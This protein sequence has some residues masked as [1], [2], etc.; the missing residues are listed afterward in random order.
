[1]V[2]T[3]TINLNKS[4]KFDLSK[5]G[6]NNGI[7]LNKPSN[8]NLNK[9]GL[10]NNP[11]KNSPFNLFNFN[12]P[13][14]PEIVEAFDGLVPIGD[15]G[16]YITP[17]SPVD[18]TD[19]DLYPDSPYCGGNPISFSTLLGIEPAIVWDECNIGVQFTPVVGFIKL[20][21]LQFVYKDPKCINP[22]KPPEVFE[23]SYEFCLPVSNWGYYH[24]C[25]TITYSGQ[26]SPN[27]QDDVR[28]HWT[29]DDYVVVEHENYTGG[30]WKK[31]DM[32]F[33][34]KFDPNILFDRICFFKDGIDS[35][36]SIK[37]RFVAFG[38][39][40]SFSV[41]LPLRWDP[42]TFK[43]ESIIPCDLKT[44]PPPL[45]NNCCCPAN[46]DLLKAILSYVET[47]TQN[48]G[49]Y[50]H[51]AVIYDQDETEPDAQKKI[52]QLN[53]VADALNLLTSRVETA[54]K[55]IGI[56]EYPASLP[57][58]LISKDEGFVGNLI[59]NP[60]V[61]IP[62]LTRL[63]GWFVER[64]DELVGQFEI[65]IEIKDTD[66]TTP[67]DQPVGLKI[68]NVA[69]GL[70]EML[71]LLLQTAYNTEALININTR[72]LVETGGDKVQNYKT[73]ML[74]EALTEYIGFKYNEVIKK[75]NLT[76]KPGA[77]GLDQMLKEHQQDVLVAD[78]D[79]KL[80]FQSD[81][82]RLLEA[83]SIVKAVHFR[84]LD[85]KGD[86][87]GQILDLLKKSLDVGKKVNG[88]EENAEGDNS[89]DQFRQEVEEG[90]INTPGVKNTTNPYGRPF[91]D[92][93]RIKDVD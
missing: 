33:T 37:W 4:L 93:P 2:K 91:E 89:F 30:Y 87:K 35:I 72:T 86:V 25:A 36:P 1:M 7:D 69:E 28:R 11:K 68:T 27:T 51:N 53:S 76:F 61:E 39:S 66:P 92:R 16:W 49:Y 82:Q 13:G 85:V 26:A 77:E 52:I 58:S 31:K 46:D 73:Y 47:I 5:P 23:N 90:F 60:N 41:P 80:D 81:L 65:P 21:P 55:I 84:R 88:N 79:E 50:P 63:V 10:S 34:W 6:Q 22:L 38:K 57:Q 12:L 19:C 67:G 14:F 32:Q 8:F 44:P 62:N 71:G 75:V 18:P 45:M 59:P 43:V 83:A 70:A 48:V 54:N 78:F 9:P 64:V 17:D 20:P 24:P 42:T 29:Q 74:L 3:K 15:S 40:S 56:E